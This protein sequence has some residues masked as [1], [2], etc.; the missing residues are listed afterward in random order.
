MG[1][2]EPVGVRLLFGSTLI[3]AWNKICD[4]RVKGLLIVRL[5]HL[6]VLGNCDEE[7]RWR[8]TD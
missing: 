8:W 6:T 1:N 5:A 4:S 7:Y 2:E 3:V